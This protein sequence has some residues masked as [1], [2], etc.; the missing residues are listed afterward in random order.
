MKPIR[1][2][3]N[4]PMKGKGRK[5]REI[6]KILFNLSSLPIAESEHYL[7][8]QLNQPLSS[9]PSSATST[10]FPCPTPTERGLSNT[11]LTRGMGKDDQG[12]RT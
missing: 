9:S 3:Q 10:D 7:I 12:Q 5:E 2:N 6:P 11:E 8:S 4:Q 1:E